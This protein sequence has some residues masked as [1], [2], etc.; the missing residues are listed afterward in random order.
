MDLPIYTSWSW[1]MLRMFN[2]ENERWEVVFWGAGQFSSFPP[3]PPCLQAGC[4][5][6]LGWRQVETAGFPS[7][8]MTRVDLGGVGHPSEGVRGRVQDVL[9]FSFF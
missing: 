4:L 3:S 6:G 1:R 8:L 9:L 2:V 7:V 5:R